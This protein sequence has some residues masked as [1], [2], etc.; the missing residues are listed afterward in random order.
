[1]SRFRLTGVSGLGPLAGVCDASGDGR[2]NRVLRKAGVPASLVAAPHAMIPLQAMYA[3]FEEGARAT[4]DELLGLRVGAAMHP[5]DFGI[6]VRYAVAA[7]TIREMVGRL[8]RTLDY[9]QPG[10]ALSMVERDGTAV[11][12]YHAAE[13]RGA[14]RTFHADHV[15]DPMLTALRVFAGP[16]WKPRAFHLPYTR[17]VHW[18]RIEEALGAPVVFGSSGAGL[19]FTSSVLDIPAA[20]PRPRVTMADVRRAMAPRRPGTTAGA[21]ASLV[22][23]SPEGDGASLSTIAGLLGV[24]ARALQIELQREGTSFREVVARMRLAEARCLLRETAMSVSDIAWTLGYSEL[25]H[26]TRAFT[27]GAGVAPS[28][29]RALGRADAAARAE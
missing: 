16:G 12:R 20:Q 10:A 17:P 14:G 18:R 2:F 11:L 9:H 25:P 1:M 29:F 27:K 28:V 7:R 24:S 5:A 6:W 13:P 22:T 21:V 19:E 3:L 15:L 26:F 8:V 23:F 4:G